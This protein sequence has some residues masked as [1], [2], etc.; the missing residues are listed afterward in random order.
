MFRYLDSSKWGRN[1]Q[2]PFEKDY[3][4]TPGAYLTVLFMLGAEEYNLLLHLSGDEI[5]RM[6]IHMGADLQP[7]SASGLEQVESSLDKYRIRIQ[8]RSGRDA[9]SLGAILSRHYLEGNVKSS[10][11]LV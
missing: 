2:T 7:I 8:C 10:P 6:F 4:G 9:H 11:S 5:E 3:T 1:G